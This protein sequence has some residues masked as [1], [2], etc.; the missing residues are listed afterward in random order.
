[1]YT[2]TRELVNKVVVPHDFKQ[3]AK[4]VAAMRVMLQVSLSL[5]LSLSLTLPPTLTHTHTHIH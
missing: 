4:D 5:S 2:Y 1:M 3:A